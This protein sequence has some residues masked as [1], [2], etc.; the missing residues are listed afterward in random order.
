MR[1]KQRRKKN[2]KFRLQIG[3]RVPE[4]LVE[5]PQNLRQLYAA[6]YARLPNDQLHGESEQKIFHEQ[7]NKKKK[8]LKNCQFFQMNGV[9]NPTGFC[10][11]TTQ[12]PYQTYCC[13]CK[14]L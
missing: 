2:G 3:V 11:N 5:L 7:T 10:Q 1:S 12:Y 13:C 6:R 9:V 8:T 4:R 14:L